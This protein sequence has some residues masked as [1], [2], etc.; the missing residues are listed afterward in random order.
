MRDLQQLPVASRLPEISAAIAKERKAVIHAEPGAGKTMLVPPLVREL[1][2]HGLT[3]LIEPRRIAAR[4][5]AYGIAELHGF[6][7]GVQCGYAVRGE[8]RRCRPDGIMAVTPGIMLQM[9]QEDPALEKVSALVFDEFHERSWEADL[10]L[11]MALDAMANLREDLLLAVMSATMEEEKLGAF[12][13]AP[14]IRVPGKNFPVTV[15]YREIADD[16]RRLPAEIARAVLE[17]CR[18]RSG[19]LLVFLPGAEEIRRCGE[20]LAAALPEGF[21]ILPLHGTLKLAEQRAALAPAPPGER[22]IVLATNVAESSLTVENITTVVDSGWEKRLCRHP[23]T[24]LD[25]LELRRITADSAIQRAGRAGRTAPGE[26][27]RCYSKLT[28][29]RFVPH[30]EPEI[31]SADLARL[32][33][34]AACWGTPPAALPFP[35]PPPPAALEAGTKLLRRLKLFDRNDL[36]TEAGRRAAS[37]PVS[38]RMA[39]MLIP[40]TPGERRTAAEFAAVLEERD[41]FRSFDTADLRERVARMDR[42]PG[43]YP[44]QTAVLR[45][46]LTEFPPAPERDAS[47]DPG[48]LIARAFPEWIGRRRNGGSTIYQLSGGGAAALEENDPLRREEFLAVARLDG[49]TGGNALIRLALPI[50]RESIETY[51]AGE[52]ALRRTALFDGDSGKPVCFEERRLGELVLS[53]RPCPMPPEETAAA[54][55]AEAHRRSIPLPPPEDRRASAFFARLRFAARGGMEGIPDVEGEDFLLSLAPFFPPG[56]SSLNDLKRADWLKILRSLLDRRVEAELDRLY[57]E[58]FTAP[59]GMKFP[60]DYSGEQPTLSIQIQQLYGVT[61]HPSVGARHIPLRIEL[62]SPARRPVQISCDLP[63]FWKGSWKLVRAEMRVRY[64]KHE[65]P[66]DPAAAAPMR[67]SVKPR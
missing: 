36:P 45:R 23:G 32:V 62:L 47:A 58:C 37:L 19:D 34:A 57:P 52:I 59:T 25:F 41:D 13:H 24:G 4:S 21:R 44:V 11:A 42:M 33:L 16:P 31:I 12:L 22:R 66:E 46:L 2:G 5:A 53:R 7:V 10:A 60:I 29:D 6:Q 50:D 55:L 48:M 27:V 30:R 39:A 35:D 1:A 65:W 61:A 3:I 64:P 15:S 28:F 18:E 49:G 14:V 43:K 40:A 67:R 56:L 8:S 63:G 26:A 9:L 17:K 38:P 20:I 51:F 54:L